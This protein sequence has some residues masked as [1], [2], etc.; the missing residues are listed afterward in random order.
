MALPLKTG[1]PF[2]TKGDITSMCNRSRAEQLY[3]DDCYCADEESIAD[4]LNPLKISHKLREISN[5][6]PGIARGTP[7]LLPKSSEI[8][9]TIKMI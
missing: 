8:V 9:P 3:T 4:E 6:P 2:F 5:R 1:E 7:R